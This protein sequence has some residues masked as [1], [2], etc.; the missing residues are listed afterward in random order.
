MERKIDFASVM[1]TINKKL[2]SKNAYN[3]TMKTNGDVKS[4]RMKLNL[5]S[6]KQHALCK[7]ATTKHA[8]NK[9]HS[10][11]N[12]KT[13]PRTTRSTKSY[14]TAQEDLA[15]DLKQIMMSQ[16]MTKIQGK[17]IIVKSTTTLKT[18]HQDKGVAETTTMKSIAS[19]ISSSP[20]LSSQ[21]AMIPKIIYHG[22]SKLI[23]SSVYTTLMKRRRLPWPHLSSK[24]MFSFGGNK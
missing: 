22:H 4:K 10:D 6:E 13:K 1:D 7:N 16:G 14:D 15:N 2:W 8:K 20:C 12:V 23:R 18:L 11:M 5:L 9:K 17:N 21:E 19:A 24:I 3:N